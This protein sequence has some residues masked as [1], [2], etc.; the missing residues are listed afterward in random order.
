MSAALPLGESPLIR[1]YAPIFVSVPRH[2]ACE[3]HHPV[4]VFPIL[5]YKAAHLPFVEPLL[6]VVAD[7]GYNTSVKCVPYEFQ[8]GGNQMLRVWQVNE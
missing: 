8:K 1:R 4:D 3:F 5:N 7:A 2:P 6:K